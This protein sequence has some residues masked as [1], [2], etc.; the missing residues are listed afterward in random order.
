MRRPP[1]LRSRFIHFFLFFFGRD[2]TDDATGI[3]LPKQA[4]GWMGRYLDQLR[5][6]PP[7]LTAP[8]VPTIVR[9]PIYSVLQRPSRRAW[10]LPTASQPASHRLRQLEQTSPNAETDT[11][12]HSILPFQLIAWARLR[13]HNT[14][15][16]PPPL[17]PPLLRRK[18]NMPSNPRSPPP[19]SRGYTNELSR[20]TVTPYSSSSSS[21]VRQQPLSCLWFVMGPGGRGR[22]KCQ[23]HQERWGVSG[24]RGKEGKGP[25]PLGRGCL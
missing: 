7:F 3:S 2:G 12:I 10:K 15:L 8:S 9:L 1:R 6:P 4:G 24:I 18:T 19:P 22:Q 21:P 20:G 17:P 14:T 13:M 23:S 25:A 11:G 5:R 16:P